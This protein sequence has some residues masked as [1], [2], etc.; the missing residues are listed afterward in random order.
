MHQTDI[1]QRLVEFITRELLNDRAGLSLDPGD[2]LLGSELVDSLGVMRIVDFLERQF[3]L[4]IPPADVTIEHFIDVRT[5]SAYVV[6]M[7]G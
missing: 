7:K 1:E 3:D 6:G 4:Q 2:D 5:I